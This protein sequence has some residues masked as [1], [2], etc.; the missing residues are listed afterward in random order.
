[1]SWTRLPSLGDRSLTLKQALP[2][3]G[4]PSG[5]PCSGKGS[6][7]VVEGRKDVQ[8]PLEPPAC[9]LR[10]EKCPRAY[11]SWVAVA[12]WHG[13]R[14]LGPATCFS[15]SFGPLLSETL[16]GQPLLGSSLT[17]HFRSQGNS[18]G[19]QR[20]R[21]LPMS[22]AIARN[23]M[24]PALVFSPCPSACPGSSPRPG[25]A[26]WST[27]GTRGGMRGKPWGLLAQGHSSQPRGG[28]CEGTHQLSLFPWDLPVQRP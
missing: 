9:E 26:H 13:G 23:Q 17:W 25:D 10:Q 16:Q 22:K 6:S 19:L 28:P 11:V 12:S 8:G 20:T 5:K 15:S 1:M 21:P 27:E 4:L 24:K 14:W 7:R 18:C 2:C 3:G